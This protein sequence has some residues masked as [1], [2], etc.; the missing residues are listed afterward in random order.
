MREVLPLISD[1]N[2]DIAGTD[3][4]HFEEE[5]PAA[6]YPFEEEIP[7]GIYGGKL[8]IRLK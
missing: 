8:K 1:T 5:M 7:V 6:I 2:P 3:K 4:E